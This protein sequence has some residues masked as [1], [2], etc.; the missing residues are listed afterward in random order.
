MSVLNSL[1]L[2]NS[3]QIIPHVFVIY[4]KCCHVNTLKSCNI[5]TIF[6]AKTRNQNIG[7]ILCDTCYCDYMHKQVNSF[8][9]AYVDNMWRM[10]GPKGSPFLVL[11]I[12]SLNNVSVTLQKDASHLHLMLCHSGGVD[13]ILPFVTCWPP[14]PPPVPTFNL[15]M[16]IS[17]WVNMS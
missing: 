16:V 4:Y 11:T 7:Y 10:R 15:L 13:H 1:S 12:P 8:L 6:D 5:S 2:L 14:P 9:Q 3:F 17:V